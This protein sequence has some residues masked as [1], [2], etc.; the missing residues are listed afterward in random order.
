M[1]IFFVWQCA[2]AEQLFSRRAKAFFVVIFGGLALL[3]ASSVCAE[4]SDAKFAKP[5]RVR[6]DNHCL[7][8][9]G[10][11]TLLFS[12][13]FHYF[14]CPKELWRA[15][16]ERIKEAG[17]NA[18]ETYIAWNAHEI[19][20]PK[21]LD[22]FSKIDLRDVEDWLNM[23]EEFGFNIIIRPGPYICAEWDRGGLPAWLV[24]KR[25]D[26]PK[27]TPWFRSD[28]P[29]FIAWS[30]HWY[31][32]VCP[33]LVKH[34]ITHK[35]PGQPGIILFQLEN[36]YDFSGMPEPIKAA[37]VKAMGE[38]AEADGIDVPLFTCWTRCVRGS[39]DP[40]LS[41]VFDSCNFYPGWNVD[42]VANN[43]R[44]L[45]TAQPQ[46]PLMTTELQGGWFT[47]ITDEPPI[48]PDTDHYRN[49]LVPAQINN[50]T[51]FTLQNGETMLNYYMLFGGTN[52]ADTAAHN[53]AT[54]YDY[55]SPIRE[56][57]GVGE[58][59]LRVKALG[60]MLK[61]HGGKLA[62]AELVN[63]DAKTDQLDVSV[64]ERRA[65]DGS[66]YLFVRTNQHAQ[67]RKGSASVR[68]TGEGGLDLKFNYDL[69]PFGSKVLYLPAGTTDPE[70]GEWLPKTQAERKRPT[71]LPAPVK[72]TQI[73]SSNLPLP[74]D[75]KPIELGKTLN[76]AGIFDNRFVYYK[77]ALKLDPKEI[78][79]EGTLRLAIDHAKDDRV[80]A[81][82]NGK[83]IPRGPDA[84][85]SNFDVQSVLHAGTNDIVL[86]YENTACANIG[87]TME[88]V[89]GVTGLRLVQGGQDRPLTNWRMQQVD[90]NANPEK[91]AEIAADFDDSKWAKTPIDKLEANQLRANQTAVFRTS[92]DLSDYDLYSG[93]CI[94][95][96]ARMDDDGWV[97]FDGKKI[98][99]GH[100]WDQ[101][102]S[103]DV[104]PHLHAGINTI[105]VV[106]RNKDNTGGLGPV[107]LAPA[108]ST[109]IGTLGPLTYGATAPVAT[110]FDKIASHDSAGSAVNESAKS[111]SLLSTHRLTFELPAAKKDVWLPWLIRLRGTGNGFIY[112]NGHAIGRFWQAGKQTDY[113]LPECWLNFGPGKPNEVTL[114]LRT[115]DKQPTIESTEA[116]PY[117]VYA[118]QR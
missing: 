111:T 108:Q 115:V 5:E 30:K 105:A 85:S 26:N 25:P 3:T 71:D 60:E 53:I 43:I 72:I 116:I 33:K 37:Y 31:D 93:P 96:L 79:A 29:Q 52:L 82:V 63:C 40:V 62:R 23:A 61:E 70:K 34:Q 100:A 64:V 86:L 114:L 46:A 94:L 102:F 69:E 97:F 15:R 112:L 76:T 104:N 78:P 110:A 68:E 21:S 51:L 9:D 117:T 90:R 92:I 38:V 6:Y 10:K 77:T 95:Q 58:K 24:N 19:E 118:E 41:R 56:N 45:R 50:L 83:F 48:R 36:E 57:G 74:A 4:T 22:D 44:M 8:I 35:A 13:A 91:L 101:T 12:G 59:F 81:M 20:E 2:F 54:C 7:T 80:A 1:P 14:R 107:V 87:N 88:K 103:F 84:A 109:G 99:E 47:G 16:F 27:H 98:G 28:D 39:T 66:R 18:V 75:W 73:Q 11:D 89:P 106:V 42:S 49:D 67:P 32:A 55:S 113:Y 17:F 65:A